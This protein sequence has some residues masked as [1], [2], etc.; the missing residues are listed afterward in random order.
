MDPKLLMQERFRIDKSLF[1]RGVILPAPGEHDDYYLVKKRFVHQGWMRCDAF[2]E[3]EK[4]WEV[5]I[6]GWRYGDE[7]REGK[8]GNALKAFL[9]DTFYFR[10]TYVMNG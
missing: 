9:S 3:D 5:I 4:R 1:W 7:K 8:E 10:C 6:G 2:Y